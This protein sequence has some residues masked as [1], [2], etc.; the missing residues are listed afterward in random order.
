MGSKS[1]KKIGKIILWVL[2]GLL[3]LDLLLVG[4]LFVPA[5]QTFA[6]NK[7]TQSISE[8]WGTELSLKDVRLTP[9][10]RLVAHELRIHDD[11]HN[12]MIYVGTVN[13]RLRGITMKPFKLKLGNVTLEDAN[14][15]IRKYKGDP[16][17]NISMWAQKFPKHEVKGTFLL[18]AQHLNM[19]NSRFVYIN[20]YQ[21]KVYDV[22][23]KP[24]VD[25]AY[26]E[27]KE[28]NWEV[29]DFIVF[30]DSVAAN[31]NHLAFNQ[32]SGFRMKDGS[33]SFSICGHELRFDDLKILSDRSVVDADLLFSYD[34]WFDYAEFL[35]SVRITAAIRHTILNMADVADFVGS[36]RGMSETL[37][38]SA[39]RLDGCVN[40]FNII[41][42]AANCGY[43]NRIHGDMELKNITDLKKA[44]LN[45]QLDSCKANVPSLA[46]LT[47]PGGK[48]L[49]INKNIAEL[50]QTYF[51]GSFIGTLTNFNTDLRASTETGD[52]QASLSSLESDGAMHLQG[53][54]NTSGLNL[55]KLTHAHKV[56]GGADGNFTFEGSLDGIG[57]DA[58]NIKTLKGHL[59]GN[60]SHIDLYGYKLRNATIDGD[61]QNKFYNVTVNSNDPNLKCDVLA[62]LDM[63]D[64][65]PLLQGNVSID[66]AALGV[67]ANRMP[68]R[69]STSIKGLDK[70]IYTIQQNPTLEAG[71]DNLTINLKGSNIDNVSGYVGCDNIRVYNNGDSLSDCRFRVT[72]INTE[73]AHKFIVSSNIANASL[74]TNYPLIDAIDSIKAIAHNYFPSLIS[75]PK[76]RLQKHTDHMATEQDFYIKAHASTYR[77]YNV[78]KLIFPNLFV[79]P[80]STVDLALFSNKQNDQISA[81]IPFFFIRD[82]IRIY[83][84]AV[85]GQSID[86][87]RL[88][89]NGTIDSLFIGKLDSRLKFDNIAMDAKSNQDSI[90]YDINWHND[91]NNNTEHRSKVAGSVNISNR[92]DIIFRLRNTSLCLN[93][94]DWHFNNSN[95]IHLKKDMV[96]IRDLVIK[97]DSSHLYINGDYSFHRNPSDLNIQ[98]EALNLA[99]INPLLSNMS[100][101]G[102]LSADMHLRNGQQRLI[103]GKLLADN[104]E[105]ND[106]SIGDLFVMAGW[107]GE[108]NIGFYGGFFRNNEIVTPGTLSSYDVQKFQEEEDIFARLQG[109]YAT[110][111]KRLEVHTTFD[112]LNAGFLDPFLSGF[113]DHIKGT[114]SGNLSFYATPDSSY[115]DGKVKVLS[116][117]MGIAALGTS[118]DVKD[119]MIRL[120]STGIFFDNMTI[121][122]ADGN[123]AI[124]R[125]SIKHKMFKNM[126]FDL[127]INTRGIMVLNTP[128]SISSPFYGKGYASGQVTITGTDKKLYFSGPNLVTLE[129]TKLYL[130][131]SS[132]SSASESSSIRFKTTVH[133]DSS[134]VE[135]KDSS[136]ELDFDFTFNVTDQADIVLLLESIGGTLNAR[137]NGNFR[138]TY[139]ERDNLNLFGNLELY[140]GDFHFSLYNIVNSRFTLVPGGSINF[141]GPLEN[142]VVHASAYKSS[143][144]SL[145][146]IVPQ[147]Y[148]ASTASSNVNAYLHLNGEIMKNIDPTFSFELPNSSPEVRNVFYNAIDTTN[149]ENMTKQFAYFMVTNNFMPNSL[150]SNSNTGGNYTLLSNLINNTLGNLMEGQK[151]SFGVIYNQASESTS[152]EYGIKANANILKDR[153]S[154]STSIGYYDDKN[155]SAANNMYGDFTVEY[156]IN[157]EG[158]WKLKAY[159]YIGEHD[160]NYYNPDVNSQIN[161]TAGVALAY[162]QSFDSR[163][164]RRMRLATEASR[165]QTKDVEKRVK[166][167]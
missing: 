109:M 79:A 155:A 144:T 150:F 67:I 73:I 117:N 9:S 153:V 165:R 127:K 154:M 66:K 89:L 135:M 22:S 99:L 143:K 108:D 141:D 10:L 145:A 5:I 57:W 15:V 112:T 71:F 31:F 101:G 20:D 142:M 147:E 81:N 103:L 44:Y 70:I 32:Y 124:L 58:D 132:A 119:Q 128:K 2:L 90:R 84:L 120:N 65:E 64:D 83:Q 107:N 33:G 13:G 80:N 140:S 98:A 137:A 160:E 27:L 139:N 21:R 163:Q 54:V 4:L 91:F 37:H 61:Y 68:K 78:L 35:D 116:A 18:T 42:L 41:N 152:A 86:Q 16:S 146:S 158:T 30:N 51:G 76:Q 148:L 133:G 106:E 36:L 105:F 19:V 123:N 95:A 62:Q 75:L 49:K 164:R 26:L 111:K 110:D 23:D 1:S 56:L 47:L 52:L 130:Q 92:E 28:I 74:E 104:F 121:S 102:L 97:N 87:E 53:D 59:N 45:V 114:A 113:S 94:I 157:K 43:S 125:G 11:H 38:L 118:Y 40:D 82:K 39:D 136:T 50:G 129:G 8:K 134:L 60:I 149:K 161:Y 138:L 77:T 17:V 166:N 12:D 24:P 151:G 46:L 3:V 14:V 72:S 167:K 93:N 100:M 55:A 122:D 162:K 69:D 115:F 25:Y 159:T 29:N 96:D 126:L 7:I 6:V 34:D 88:K 63:T 156:N 85:D 48:T 131:V